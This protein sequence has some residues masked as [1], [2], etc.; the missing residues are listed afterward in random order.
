[1]L[2][3]NAKNLFTIGCS[4]YSAEHLIGRLKRN[5]IN[6]V[7]DVRSVPY[8]RHTPQFNADVLKRA[9]QL[10]NIVYMDFSKEFGAR[11]AEKEAYEKNRVSFEKV[12]ELPAFLQGVE[13]IK[14]G[15]NSN[16]RIAMMCT[17]KEPEKCHRFSLVARGIE[18]KI[19]VHSFHIL[20]DGSVVTKESIENRLIQN[21][22]IVE[23]LFVK[24][25]P[26][27]LL[28]ELLEKQVAYTINGEENDD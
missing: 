8:S 19:N 2:T 5:E 1:M 11:R 27:E 21:M 16:Y 22:N 26:V 18:K 12:M 7:V 9:L 3:L 13:R 28:Y 15:L 6:V 17:E 14:N 10:Q 24:K 23:D 4:S 25:T 20:H